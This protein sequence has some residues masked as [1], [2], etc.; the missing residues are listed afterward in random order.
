MDAARAGALLPY[1]TPAERAE[2]AALLQALPIWTPQ[3]GPQ[4][5][6]AQSRADVIGYGG[7]AGGGKTDL[8]L[9]LALTEHSRVQFF[10]REGTEI[11]GAVE[12]CVEIVGH[13]EGLGGKPTI[14]RQPTARCKSI[15]FLSVPNPG[16]ELKMRGRAKDLLVL[17]EADA[18]LE[19]QYRF[20]SG[21][22]RTVD[23]GQRC[24]T[25]L[26]FNPPATVEGRWLVRY[27]APWLDKKHPNPALPGE[28]RWFAMLDGKECEVSG[29]EP[30]THG[31][32]TVTPE[33][34]T[35][36]P[37]K[38]TDNAYL[39]GTSYVTKL[40]S[41][42]EPLRSQLLYGDFTAG[43]QDDPQQV[44]PT[45]W[46]EAAMKRWEPL[47]VKPPMTVLGVDVARGGR[48]QTVLAARHGWWYDTL[49]VEPGRD[50]PDG[51][52]VA[53]MAIAKARDRAPIAIDVVGVGASPYDVLRG[54]G[55]QVVGVNGASTPTK[56][57]KSGL[58]SFANMRS[59]LLWTMRE[60]LDPESNRGVA[61]PNDPQLLEELCAP[62]WRLANKCIVVQTREEVM[63]NLGRSPDRMAAVLLAALEIPKRH[64]LSAGGRFTA[65]PGE[66][67]SLTTTAP[68]YN[69]YSSESDHG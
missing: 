65:Q 19:S 57:D 18:F 63:E 60:M 2:V 54:I 61:L 27:F 8:A 49:R 5:L 21:W 37:A 59:Q 14:W 48:D 52:T 15:E 33:S 51:E 41:L 56:R 3:P 30:F 29:P 7:A 68:D 47:S 25:L 22:V 11:V 9:G 40:Q 66:P 69:P 16:D 20:L 42:P 62:K 4:T 23:R 58:L 36:V 34:R 24:R 38:V 53:A 1:L 45:A 35:F 32:E 44:I 10:R 46:V 55:V 64:E 28:L 6:A 31:G 43:T 26:C 67:G 12:R 17:D 50:T 13:R 39:R